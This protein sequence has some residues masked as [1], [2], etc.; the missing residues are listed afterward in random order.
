MD[1]TSSGI[2]NPNVAV[3]SSRDEQIGRCVVIQAENL[4]RVSSEVF[5]RQSLYEDYKSN[6]GVF[7][8]S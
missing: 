2:P 3:A 4:F 7:D 6:E 1:K 8:K 5:V